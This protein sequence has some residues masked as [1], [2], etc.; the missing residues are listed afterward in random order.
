MTVITEDMLRNKRLK[1]ELEDGTDFVF[2][3][4]SF[5]TPAAKSYL[6]EHRINSSFS[7]TI[8][9]LSEV[10][11]VKASSQK[12]KQEHLSKETI[13]EIRHL[14]HLLY[15][16]FLTNEALSTEGWLYFEQQQL[17]LEKFILEQSLVMEPVIL[18]SKVTILTNQQRQWRYSSKEIQLQL[19]KIILQLKGESQLFGIFQSWATELISTMAEI[20]RN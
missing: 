3:V 15:L 16:P 6:R 11:S 5:L 12:Q 14:S 2:P 10:H 7:S 4:G 17:W 20:S 19:D 8:P 1:K 9:L 13:Y 18:E